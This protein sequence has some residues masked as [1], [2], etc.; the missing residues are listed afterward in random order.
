MVR[1]TGGAPITGIRMMTFVGTVM[2]V[3]LSYVT[4]KSESVVPACILHGSI[5]VIGETPIFIA[6]SSASCLLGPSPTGIIGIIRY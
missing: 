1:V 3:L 6:A 2:G 5:N 4:L